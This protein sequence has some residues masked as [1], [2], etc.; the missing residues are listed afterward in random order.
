MKRARCVLVSLELPTNPI[1]MNLSSSMADMP[2]VRCELVLPYIHT[3]CDVLK[4]TRIGR[5]F[6]NICG[7]LRFPV[8]GQNGSLLTVLLVPLASSR[9]STICAASLAHSFR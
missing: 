9:L 7:L 2:F 3:L 6:G 5:S 8:H 1:L 4:Q